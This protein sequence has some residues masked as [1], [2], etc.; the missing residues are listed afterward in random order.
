MTYSQPVQKK[1]V[2]DTLGQNGDGV[3]TIDSQRVYVS[4]TAP[5]D[6]VAVELALTKKN[7]YQVVSHEILERG[8]N[9]SI[10]PCPHYGVCGSCQLQHINHKTYQHFKRDKIL[11]PLYY[12]GFTQNIDTL[13]GEPIIL[14]PGLRRRANFSFSC[15]GASVKLGYYKYHSHELLTLE[16]CLVLRPEIVSLIKP[17]TH[18]IQESF[19]AG[20]VGEI[21]ITLAHNGLDMHVEVQDKIPLT[22]KQ[23][24]LWAQFA[25]C[26][27]LCRLTVSLK[28]R[29]DFIFLREIPVVLFDG[30]PVESHCKGFLQPSQEADDI[31]ATIITNAI[32]PTPGKIADLFCGRGTLTLP[33]SRLGQVDAYEMDESALAAL[34]T[35]VKQCQRPVK[36]IF[37]DLFNTPLNQKDFEDYDVVVIDPPRAGAESQIYHLASSCVT[38]IIYVSCNPL[39]FARDAHILVQGGYEVASIQPVDQFRWTVHIEI[40]AKFVKL[41]T[42]DYNFASKPVII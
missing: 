21:F 22:L 10:P 23:R 2:I 4:Y 5:G 40:I 34:G 17:L 38:T 33:L 14:P 3:A 7:C 20:L 25:T 27:T 16:H 26:Y 39:T 24:E 36:T 15:H 31:L 30:V 6:T 12:R 13:V 35:A 29:E 42:I 19:S 28:G 32:S 8:R 18:A 11:K 1:L 41:S 9:Y 37:R